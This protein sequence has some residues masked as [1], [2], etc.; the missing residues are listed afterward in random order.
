M[1]IVSPGNGV[2]FQRRPS[3][4]AASVQVAAQ[5]DIVAPQW[6]RLTRSGNT[7]TAD[8]SANGTVWTTLGSVDMPMLTDVYIGLCL[9]SHNTA[10]T[11]TAEFSNVTLPSTATGDWQSQ[12]IGI[13]S[14]VPE[15]LYVAVQDAASNIAV[16]KHPDP[17]S[18]AIGTWTKWD[19]PLSEFVGV[20]MKDVKKL[21]I[22]VGDKAATQAGGAGDLYIDDIG[23]QIP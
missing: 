19:I 6:V 20:N 10:A 15:G 4:G 5:P 7:F 17:G 23:L 2:A 9:T 11:C 8:Y 22:G 12:D 13:Q 18:S 16:V 3:L 14:N 1:M 21:V